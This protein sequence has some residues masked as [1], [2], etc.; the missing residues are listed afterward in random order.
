MYCAS[1]GHPDEQ[2]DA[3]CYDWLSALS[4]NDLSCW[5]LSTGI[6]ADTWESLVGLLKDA[7]QPSRT[8]DDSLAGVWSTYLLNCP[9]DCTYD[10][11]E[12]DQFPSCE[13]LV[14]A[15]EFGDA[16]QADGG[17]K[18]ASWASSVTDFDYEC[19]AAAYNFA[20]AD[21]KEYITGAVEICSGEKQEDDDGTDGDSPAGEL[22]CAASL[23]EAWGR[24]N[25]DCLKDCTNDESELDRYRRCREGEREHAIACSAN[26][27]CVTTIDS[28]GD[29]DYECLSQ[30]LGG[31][32]SGTDLRAYIGSAVRGACDPTC[33]RAN[34]RY[35]LFPDICRQ[36]C[37]NADEEKDEDRDDVPRCDDEQPEWGV[38]CSAPGGSSCAQV[39]AALTE[40]D[41]AC[42][43]SVA[44]GDISAESVL[45]QI[46]YIQSACSI[47][48]PFA[49]ESDCYPENTDFEILHVSCPRDCVLDEDEVSFGVPLC[50]DG[51]N[52]FGVRCSADDRCL[53]AAQAVLTVGHKQCAAASRGSGVQIM[54]D[55]LLH[56]GACQPDGFCGGEGLG[57]TLENDDACNALFSNWDFEQEWCQ[58]MLQA[59]DGE[60][61][62]GC[63]QCVR[64]HLKETVIA[65]VC[66]G[67]V[68]VTG[69]MQLA[70][71]PKDGVA[72]V[73]QGHNAC[74]ANDN[75][76]WLE[77]S[78]LGGICVPTAEQSDGC[79]RKTERDCNGDCTWAEVAELCVRLDPARVAASLLQHALDV[80]PLDCSS[81][82]SDGSAADPFTPS[83]C[84]QRVYGG[85]CR[86]SRECQDALEALQPLAAH[87]PEV[88]NSMGF[89]DNAANMW[90]AWNM[91]TLCS[92][93]GPQE[94]ASCFFHCRNTDYS[95]FTGEFC[96]DIKK[97][98]REPCLRMCPVEYQQY[99]ESMRAAICDIKRPDRYDDF[100]DMCSGRSKKKCDTCLPDDGGSCEWTGG[101]CRWR[102]PNCGGHSPRDC[103]DGDGCLPTCRTLQRGP[104]DPGV[105]AHMTDSCHEEHRE[106]KCV[107]TGRCYWHRGESDD[108]GACEP[109]RGSCWEYNSE[110][111]C[112]VDSHRNECRWRDS[113]CEQLPEGCERHVGERDCT[114]DRDAACMWAAEWYSCRNPA[115]YCHELPE[116]VCDDPPEGFPK[117]RA[118]VW[119]GDYC[120]EKCNCCYDHR[121][122]EETCIEAGCYYSATGDCNN[123]PMYCGEIDSE[124]Q[125]EGDFEG[126][127]CR[128]QDDS[129]C[130]RAEAHDCNDRS[131]AECH[132]YAE[133]ICV[134]E[135]DEGCTPQ[136]CAQYDSPGACDGRSS[137]RCRWRGAA[138]F[139]A[140]LEV[141]DECEVYESE[142]ACGAHMLLAGATD[143]CVW[144]GGLCQSAACNEMDEG[145]CAEMEHCLVVKRKEEN[146][147]ESRCVARTAA[148]CKRLEETQCVAHSD[149]C[150]AVRTEGGEFDH[151]A[152]ACGSAADQ[153]SCEGHAGAGCFWEPAEDACLTRGL[154]CFALGDSRSC[155]LNALCTWTASHSLDSAP[156]DGECHEDT[157]NNCAPFGGRESAC[158]QAFGFSHCKLRSVQGGS[159]AVC[160][161]AA[162]DDCWS[163]LDDESC[164]AADSRR[165]QHESRCMWRARNDGS[166]GFC[167]EVEHDR[168]RCGTLAADDSCAVDSDGKCSVVAS[169]SFEP[170]CDR[171]PDYC[172]EI[173]VASSCASNTA[174]AGG[175]GCVWIDDEHNRYC[176][177]FECSHLKDSAFCSDAL[178][179]HGCRWEAEQGECVENKLCEDFHNEGTCI[180]H[181]DGGICEWTHVSIPTEDPAKDPYFYT[182]CTD[183]QC[184]SIEDEDECVDNRD[185]LRKA[186]CMWAPM[187]GG[188]D[189]C[190]PQMQ[191][192]HEYYFH[193]EGRRDVMA[194]SCL[195]HGGGGHCLVKRHGFNGGDLSCQEIE[196]GCGECSVDG[197]CEDCDEDC[198][199]HQVQLGGTTLEMCIPQAD[200]SD[201]LKILDEGTC[202]RSDSCQWYVSEDE[203]QAFCNYA[204]DECMRIGQDATE[205]ERHEDCLWT[206]APRGGD[207]ARCT[208]T[209]ENCWDYRDE[210]KAHCAWH[211]GGDAC[212]LESTSH[213]ECQDVPDWWSETKCDRMSIKSCK[214]SKAAKKGCARFKE[215]AR[216]P[217]MCVTAA[218]IADLRNHRTER[219]LIEG[220]VST[221]ALLSLGDATY[222]QD[223]KGKAGVRVRLPNDA[224]RAGQEVEITALVS[225][226]FQDGLTLEYASLRVMGM[227]EAKPRVVSVKDVLKGKAQ[228]GTLV[229]LEGAFYQGT[230]DTYSGRGNL[231]DDSGSGLRVQFNGDRSAEGSLTAYGTWGDDLPFEAGTYFGAIT[232]IIKVEGS[233]L[234]LIPRKW[235]DVIPGKAKKKKKKSAK[236]KVRI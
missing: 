214:K 193:D 66:G 86:A 6:S 36:D 150:A 109:L 119:N 211:G 143:V 121:G 229:V 122:N 144:D 178:G 53:K 183:R 39:L 58:T 117:D 69:P 173:R 132:A 68:D 234:M 11:A 225:P 116:S 169:P 118:C 175:R 224:V 34:A 204:W 138:D 92:Y 59:A 9:K 129:Y 88:L 213:G 110:Q 57:C 161:G 170:F 189:A 171:A 84:D 139:G 80:C 33:R 1:D 158:G 29:H 149:L 226:E 124:E 131:A 162:T 94:D 67:T 206:E 72:C 24:Y 51:Q 55:V 37:H 177:E 30:T 77:E 87:L 230:Y 236:K 165:S 91:I 148:I 115:E 89:E 125:C 48:D 13:G 186:S 105:C 28:L 96:G 83:Y 154:H 45:G 191:H 25:R 205:C 97:S 221:N 50:S 235:S 185:G 222:V 76:E 200:N 166:G 2:A 120:E 3:T 218:Q 141:G 130:E 10:E 85:R 168:A 31:F 79:A 38:S 151:C 195:A 147:W 65:P 8:C 82:T 203:S 157:Y 146:W 64:D 198:K 14:R 27:R 40:E 90:D 192:C 176:T 32:I 231:A 7:C 113:Y 201:C 98:M 108:F 18:C 164:T 134:P 181:A 184:L 223:F 75:C 219:V 212:V 167:E 49:L 163:M 60:C 123:P 41:I 145:A 160:K 17:D 111:A 106:T 208:P 232:G 156:T 62:S 216:S 136:A 155:E 73:L 95:S 140:C 20:T 74:D 15:S 137:S 56:I 46:R 61:L 26:D 196:D 81:E 12:L 159:S 182:Y 70:G 220:V 172:H 233:D 44:G 188:R 112:Q 23:T 174:L 199:P 52:D 202:G 16:C 187:G 153:L 179:G 127:L 101:E 209:P 190:L 142:T 215:T 93:D 63:S 4:D 103:P 217:D 207:F 152:T 54:T 5:A 180:A 21:V 99:G 114:A 100:A 43:P 228:P 22:D 197:G 194:A 35:A 227:G 128:W 104:E 47:G 78:A 210:L 126:T 135:A 42:H 107:D 19:L 71:E 133:E 102:S